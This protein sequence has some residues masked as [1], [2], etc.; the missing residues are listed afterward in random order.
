MSSD[1]TPASYRY[2]QALGPLARCIED[3]KAQKKLSEVLALLDFNSTLNRSLEL[4]EILDLVLFVAMGETR[5]SWAGVL[6]RENEGPLRTPTPT[7][8]PTATRRGRSDDRWSALEIPGPASPPAIAGVGDEDVS[9]WARDVLTASGAALLVPLVKAERLVGVLLLGDRGEPYG[10]EE[11]LFA[12]SAL[13]FRGSRD[14]QRPRLRGGSAPQPAFVAEGLSAR[15]S[16]R[17]HP[18]AQSQSRCLQSSR[19]APHQRDGSRPHDARVDVARWSCRGAKRVH[20][21]ARGPSAP[22]SRQP[23]ARGAR[24]R[25]LS[26]RASRGRSAR[27]PAPSRHR[28][29]DPAAI[30][31]ELP[32]SASSR[33]PSFWKTVG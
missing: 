18:R 1:E 9:V 27:Y 5:A 23:Q 7:P 6:L 22:R 4:S 19:S 8:M 25:E 20:V 11:R 33:A 14:R 24:G 29:R 10:A 15:L 17:Y 31:R 28:Y 13:R 3:P 16:V 30:G 21:D 2:Q 26:R 32:W 12:E